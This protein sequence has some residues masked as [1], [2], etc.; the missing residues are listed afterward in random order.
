MILD[1]YTQQIDFI[2]LLGF[3]LSKTIA[4]IRSKLAMPCRSLVQRSKRDAIA[5]KIV[6]RFIRCFERDEH[7]YER[8]LGTNRICPTGSFKCKQLR[9]LFGGWASKLSGRCITKKLATCICKRLRK[10]FE[11]GPGPI[12]EPVRLQRLLQV[13]R[14]KRIQKPCRSKE[15]AMDNC[16]TLPMD[17][18]HMQDHSM[19][20][21][22]ACSS[23][24]STK[25]TWVFFAAGLP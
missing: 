13:A 6:N 3:C 2:I 8:L 4:C 20:K 18:D 24:Q 23:M 17:I 11:L 25:V 19:P 5:T 7:Q 9:S 21:L 12:E 14:K 16:E 22:E 10:H 1:R 15:K